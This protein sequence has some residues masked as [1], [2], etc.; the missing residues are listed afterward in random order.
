MKKILFVSAVLAVLCSCAKEELSD[1]VLV[2]S[3]L[4]PITLT[5]DAETEEGDVPEVDGTKAWTNYKSGKFLFVWNK[6]GGEK[7]AA[8]DSKACK[9]G[10]HEFLTQ[11]KE[12]ATNTVEISGSVCQDATGKVVFMFPRQANT[13]DK[14][15]DSG[16]PTEYKVHFE[17]NYDVAKNKI[18]EVLIPYD[19]LTLKNNEL[20]DG[21]IVRIGELPSKEST[22]KLVMYNPFAAFYFNLTNSGTHKVTRIEIFGNNREKLAGYCDISLAQA[23]APKI[24]FFP[25]PYLSKANARRVA[26]DLLLNTGGTELGD[27]QYLASLAPTNFTKGLTIK[28]FDNHGN[29]AF[30]TSTTA[31]NVE[32]NH[33]KNLGTFNVDNLDWHLA[34]NLRFIPGAFLKTS[35][36]PF[37]F[38]EGVITTKNTVNTQHYTLNDNGTPKVLDFKTYC[39]ASGSEIGWWDNGFNIKGVG[40]YIEIPVVE[41]KVLTKIFYRASAT[42]GKNGQP[43]IVRVSDGKYLAADGTFVSDVVNAD[44]WTGD[45]KNKVYFGEFKVWT[46]NFEAGKSYRIYL[47]NGDDGMKI[48][49]LVLLYDDATKATALTTPQVNDWNLG[50]GAEALMY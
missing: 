20:I 35:S 21:K 48:M 25:S 33:I 24:E 49:D 16:K 10:G 44:I 17:N 13:W 38:N 45:S 47:T 28:F 22:D 32:R 29:V 26:Y 30:K 18:T 12:P 6:G 50:E 37:P 3:G 27:A 31:L 7:V 5:V 19:Y 42:E 36:T 41:G 8:F 15:W 14:T 1:Q 4:Y 34:A 11:A 9:V 40:A 2:D 39:P 43:C 23:G 46:G